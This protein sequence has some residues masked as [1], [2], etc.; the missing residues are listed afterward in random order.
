MMRGYAQVCDQPIYLL[1]AMISEEISEE[2]EIVPDK[3][4]SVVIR[5]IL[6]CIF[7]LIKCNKSSIL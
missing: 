7:I 2:P 1:K 5:N 3:N 6:Q 4:E